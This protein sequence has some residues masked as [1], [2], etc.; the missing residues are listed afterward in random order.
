MRASTKKIAFLSFLFLLGFT[1]ARAESPAKPITIVVHGKPGSA[2]DIT[3]RQIVSISRKFTPVPMLVENKS[4]GS[5]IVAMQTVLSRRA[6]LRQPGWERVP[7]PLGV[8]RGTGRI[9]LPSEVEATWLGESSCSP[10]RC[11]GN[12]SNPVAK[13]KELTLNL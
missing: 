9:R 12:A 13:I 1:K 6:A 4:G 2:M 3:A 8:A 7:V 5:G 11:S 10:R